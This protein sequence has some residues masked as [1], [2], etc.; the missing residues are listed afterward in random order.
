MNL[1]RDYVFFFVKTVANV[2][3]S[4]RFENGLQEI[5]CS[6]MDTTENVEGLISGTIYIV[7]WRK[8][9]GFQK[10]VT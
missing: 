3:C 7:V 8:E 2:N 5:I 10:M 1:R 9:S 4:S 6:R